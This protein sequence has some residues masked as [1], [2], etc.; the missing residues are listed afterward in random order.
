MLSLRKMIQ[1]NE[2]VK[3]KSKWGIGLREER[4]TGNRK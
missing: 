2:Q 3:K 1:L 4:E